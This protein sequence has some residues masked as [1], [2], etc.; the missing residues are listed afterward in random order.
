MRALLLNKIKLLVD[1]ALLKSK[2]DFHFNPLRQPH[3][4]AIW[5]VSLL[6]SKRD[7]TRVEELVDRNFSKTAA[8]I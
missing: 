1:G 4:A 8:K 6:R 2:F 5:P 7:V 3:C